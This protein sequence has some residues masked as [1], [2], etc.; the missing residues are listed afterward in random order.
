MPML[1]KTWY[2]SCKKKK[3]RGWVK[4]DV[5][6]GCINKE[7]VWNVAKSREP[8]PPLQPYLLYASR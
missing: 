5:D 3:S 2:C 1:H 6:V 7:R 4:V 8:R